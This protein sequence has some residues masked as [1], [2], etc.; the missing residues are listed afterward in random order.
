MM[1]NL[2]QSSFSLVPPFLQ[3]LFSSS[4]FSPCLLLP[5]ILILLK[6]PLFQIVYLVIFSPLLTVVLQVAILSCVQRKTIQLV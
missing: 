2:K 4:Q 3:F 5:N 6:C 1:K